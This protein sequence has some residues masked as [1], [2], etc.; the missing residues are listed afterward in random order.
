M[1]LECGTYELTVLVEH[2]TVAVTHRTN[3]SINCNE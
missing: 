1:P 2:R 3:A